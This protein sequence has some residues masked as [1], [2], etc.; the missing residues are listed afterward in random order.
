MAT[1]QD[2]F[3][4]A[5]KTDPSRTFPAILGRPGAL[6]PAG[7]VLFVPGAGGGRFS[8]RNQFVASELRRSG[9]ATL[10]VDLLSEEEKYQR[11]IRQDIPLL[12]SRV[13]AVVDWIRTTT[14]LRSLPLAFFGSS[15]G[16]AAMFHAAARVGRDVQAIVCRG[17]R[18]DLCQNCLKD[19][20]SPS[21]LIVGEH[22]RSVLKVNRAAYEELSGDRELIIV[23][24]ASH[25]FEE[26]G[27][28]GQ[29]ARH[30]A[31]WYSSHFDAA[32]A[33]RAA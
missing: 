25:Y 9:I 28:L 22:D 11:L 19:V 8:P 33:A 18:P 2:I 15:T 5:G 30:A 26:P 3:I 7:L 24:K 32:R 20:K 4:P 31:R 21:L 1:L 29:V 13:V 23:P 12:S 6:P 17:G 16:A 14:P 27:A 10:L